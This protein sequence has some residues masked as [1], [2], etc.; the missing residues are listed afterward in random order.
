MRLNSSQ[1][2]LIVED[3]DEDYEATIR[4]FSKSS[5]RNPVFR[6][7][8]GNDALDY[9]FSRG[10]YTDKEKFPRPGIILLDLN[11]PVTNGRE[12][13]KHIKKDPA[14]KKIPVIVLTTSD[15]KVDIMQCYDEGANSY[16]HK[17]VDL[18]RFMEAIERLR[19]YWFEIVILPKE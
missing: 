6:C 8:D 16:I 13:L 7:A 4:A 18:I 17:P 11:L 9:V 2:I 19:E 1:L 14:T 15:D 10:N 5:L 12:V 3:S